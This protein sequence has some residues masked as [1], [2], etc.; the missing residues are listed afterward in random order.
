MEGE[1]A[2]QIP[3]A[4]KG[5]ERIPIPDGKRGNGG[6]DLHGGIYAGR[7]KR[8]GRGRDGG[9]KKPVGRAGRTGNGEAGGDGHGHRARK[10]SGS[11]RANGA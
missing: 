11:E 8:A 4:R 1:S 9:R 7:E 10:R 3:D 6:D 2:Q 5:R